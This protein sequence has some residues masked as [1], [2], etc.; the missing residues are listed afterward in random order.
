VFGAEE[1]IFSAQTQAPDSALRR[2]RKT[3]ELPDETS[4]KAVGEP[5]AVEMV[6]SPET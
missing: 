2:A 1:P 6:N 4:E 5:K 3:S